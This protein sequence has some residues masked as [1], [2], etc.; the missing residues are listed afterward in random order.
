MSRDEA[1]GAFAFGAVGGIL[2]IEGAEL[3]A[4]AAR[5]ERDPAGS[6]DALRGTRA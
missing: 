2:I 1:H 3:A 4:R 6:L 5:G